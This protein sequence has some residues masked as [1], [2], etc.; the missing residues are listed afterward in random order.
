MYRRSRPPSTP[1]QPPSSPAPR[2]TS[3]RVAFDSSFQGVSRL[4]R[5]FFA[6]TV[7]VCRKYT[8]SRPAHGASAPLARDFRGSGT[9]RSGSSSS[10]VPRPPHA[11][12]APYGLLKENIRGETSGNEM[13]QRT[14]ARRSE[15]TQA[16]PPS[17]TSTT[18]TPSASR[19]AVSSE[20][21][22]R[23]APVSRMT[24]RSTTTSIV[25]FL[26]LSSSISSARSRT[27][28]LT[29]T[30]PNPC[31][32]SSNRSFRYS[33]LRPRTT[34]ASTTT[35]VPDGSVR[36]RSTICWTV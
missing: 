17:G 8:D 27:V 11:G 34:G 22:S 10:R 31:R 36:T 28:P 4:K 21:A 30:R 35:R 5:R 15:N 29:R 19:S 2:R 16:W 25:C 9:T 13:P 3:S 7:R 20:S 23:A 33:P 26:F 12:Q 1:S 6:S 18:T 24:R 32:R 14:H